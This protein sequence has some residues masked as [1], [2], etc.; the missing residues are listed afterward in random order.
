M[1]P[2]RAS[3]TDFD[4]VPGPAQVKASTVSSN[5][6]APVS[7]GEAR[8]ALGDWRAPTRPR[9]WLPQALTVLKQST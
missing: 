1:H 9:E 5:R 3:R 6:S 8:G 7:L 2:T 4:V